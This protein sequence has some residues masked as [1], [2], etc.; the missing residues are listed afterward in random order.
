MLSNNISGPGYNPDPEI[1]KMTD[2]EILQSLEWS[3]TPGNKSLYLNA[4]QR[5]RDLL[6]RIESL[7]A[8]LAES[9]RNVRKICDTCNLR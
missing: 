3:W 7:Q 5:L 9:Q 4:A 1:E 8:Q 6:K 2:E